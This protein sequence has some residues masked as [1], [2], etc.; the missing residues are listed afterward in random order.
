[1]PSK[2][3]KKPSHSNADAIFEKISLKN[4]GIKTLQD[5]KRDDLDFYD[6]AVWDIKKALKSAYNAGRKSM[7]IKK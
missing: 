1:M 2:S 6:L 7:R 5:R 3:T 4:L